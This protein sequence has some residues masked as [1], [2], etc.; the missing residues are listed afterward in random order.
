MQIESELAKFLTSPVMIIVGTS[1][2][3]GQSEIARG[4]GARVD[5]ERGVVELLFSGWQWPATMNNLR[6]NPRIAVTFARPNDYVSYQVKGRATLRDAGAQDISFSERYLTDIAEVLIG[7][8]MNRELVAPWL[9]NRE[10]VVA[11][12]NVDDIYV[13]TPGTGA[14]QKLG[15]CP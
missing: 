8:G 3:H 4:A 9:M 1:D 10:A 2:A 11:H 12:I 13:Q 7:L 6:A 15:P 14:G 5:A